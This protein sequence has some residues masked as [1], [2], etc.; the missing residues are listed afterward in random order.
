MLFDKK[1][2]INAYDKTSL[3]ENL[4]RQMKLAQSNDSYVQEPEITA[5]EKDA[6]IKKAIE[7]QEGLRALGQAMTE[8]IRR[9]LD[10]IGVGRKALVIDHVPQ[11]AIMKY[12]V[13]IDVRAV[14]VAQNGT[15]I[16]SHVKG[17]YA[18]LPEYE[19]ACAPSIS[20]S[21]VQRRSFDIIER[22]KKKAIQEINALEDKAI[23][24][25]LDAASDKNIMG[26]NDRVAFANGPGSSFE[27]IDFISLRK[28]ITKWNNNLARVFMHHIQTNDILAWA[29]RSGNGTTTAGGYDFVTARE[30]IQT[31]YVSSVFGVE[32]F[33]S[34]V[35]QP[36]VVY[37][38]ADPECVGVFAIRNDIAIVPA[39]IPRE[40]KIG[41]S[42]FEIVG[43]GVLNPR[44]VASVSNHI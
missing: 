34:K 27:F 17:E 10:Y 41:W 40:R 9:N 32:I 7:S 11:G 16:E 5:A 33:A 21:E 12:D 4:A 24:S 23:F 6:L 22:T 35:V 28:Q 30:I 44:G 18:L 25:A 31:G 39:D 42:I 43:I 37:G 14:I 29:T 15:S 26:E 38:V 8:P 1:G 3:I 13:D 2:N 20:I 19:I 36:G